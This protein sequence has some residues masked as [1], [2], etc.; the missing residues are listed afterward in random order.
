MSSCSFDMIE[1][2][3]ARDNDVAITPFIV[4]ANWNVLQYIFVSAMLSLALDR[5]IDGICQG[6][7]PLALLP[8]TIHQQSFDS[9]TSIRSICFSN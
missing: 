4:Y 1:Q 8:R 2:T 3:K 5:S 7:V 6:N 9:A